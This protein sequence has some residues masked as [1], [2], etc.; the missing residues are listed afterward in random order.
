MATVVQS[1]NRSVSGVQR[2]PADT[3]VVVHALHKSA[4]MFL[5]S[6]FQRL[7]MR[8]GL[9]YFSVNLPDG[10]PLPAGFQGKYCHCPIRTFAIEEDESSESGVTRIFQVRDPRDILVSEY[11]SVAYIHPVNDESLKKRRVEAQKMTV[12]EYA[13]RQPEFSASP[14]EQKFQPLLDRLEDTRESG[15]D[16]NDILVRYETM[17]SRFHEWAS[18][19]IV[20]FGFQFPRIMAAKLAWEYRKDFVPPA[21]G[22]SMT[23][24]RRITPGDFRRK[25][26]PETIEILNERF[27]P[28]LEAFGY[29]R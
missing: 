1:D 11:Y 19:V 28:I 13:I 23:H 18:A 6:F 27:A 9:E 16:C 20:P 10:R 7:S 12:E 29:S 15:V 14:L 24:K 17:V 26:S 22:D 8:A 21:E 5:F 3:G 25:F 4:S 2:K